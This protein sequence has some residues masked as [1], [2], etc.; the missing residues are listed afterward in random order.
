MRKATH[1]GEEGSRREPGLKRFDFERRISLLLLDALAPAKLQTGGVSFDAAI[2]ACQKG[3]QGLRGAPPCP[4][5]F[6]VGSALQAKLHRM[7]Q[8]GTVWVL[9]SQPVREVGTGMWLWM[10]GRGQFSTLH[11]QHLHRMKQLAG[12]WQAVPCCRMQSQC[13]SSD[14][15]SISAIVNSCRNGGRWQ[16]ALQITSSG[17]LLRTVRGTVNVEQDPADFPV[18]FAGS[19]PSHLRSA[20]VGACEASDVPAESLGVSIMLKMTWFAPTPDSLIH[21]ASV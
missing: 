1:G 17:G 3:H 9:L 13:L 21:N 18:T 7:D 8:V 10:P 11:H 5:R 19:L 20:G 14:E 12:C 4:E 15:T 2:S 6:G 16:L